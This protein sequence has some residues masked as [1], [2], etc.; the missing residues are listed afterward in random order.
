L[1]SK[2]KTPP[3]LVEPLLEA[4]ELGVGFLVHK[5]EFLK[6]VYYSA[7]PLFPQSAR[8]IFFSSARMII[9]SLRERS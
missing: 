3:E 5:D 1:L 6:R 2:S 7:A 4:G 8:E 9:A